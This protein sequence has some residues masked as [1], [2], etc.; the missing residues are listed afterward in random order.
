MPPDHFTENAAPSAMPAAKR[1]GRQRG[2]GTVERARATPI[3][4][5]SGAS[6]GAPTETRSG[7]G[8]G[9]GGVR[10]SIHR[11]SNRRNRNPTTT[12]NSR[13]MSSSAE[14]DSTTFRFSTASNSPATNVQSA[15][16]NNSCAMTATNVTMSVP[17]TADEN[18]H[19]NGVMPNSFSPMP[20]VHLPS[21]G[22]THEPTSHLCSRQ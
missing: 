16:P 1:H 10:R 4:S 5:I 13:W 8:S 19:P 12:Q 2:N 14:R 20:I 17:A 22:W 11:R 6:L 9:S 15:L 18:R 21:G 3:S 7:S